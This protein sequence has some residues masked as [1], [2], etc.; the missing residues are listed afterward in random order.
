[1]AARCI[2]SQQIRARREIVSEADAILDLAAPGPRRWR[3]VDP[4]AERTGLALP[5]VADEM[6]DENTQSTEV[7]CPSAPLATGE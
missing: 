7:G 5:V 3:P 2:G 6:V 1:M 4:L